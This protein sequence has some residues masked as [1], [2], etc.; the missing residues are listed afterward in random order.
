MPQWDTSKQPTHNP[1]LPYPTGMPPWATYALAYHT[2]FKGTNS[3]LLT[4]IITHSTPDDLIA[5]VSS[6]NITPRVSPFLFSH[7]IDRLSRSHDPAPFPT[8]IAHQ[9]LDAFL[10]RFP[11]PELSA[12]SPYRELSQALVS[13]A[14]ITH[15]PAFGEWFTPHWLYQFNRFSPHPSFPLDSYQ[16]VEAEDTQYFQRLIPLLLAAPNRGE[17]IEHALTIV[18]DVCALLA[19]VAPFSVSNAMMAHAMARATA[20]TRPKLLA[21]LPRLRATQEMAPQ[22]ARGL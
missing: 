16:D 1:I 7:L 21:L 9:I 5:L 17:L 12:L 13:Y 8:S 18:P 14:P 6:E 19:E 22:Y 4:S 15:Y 11:L 20:P 10:A 3:P 2:P